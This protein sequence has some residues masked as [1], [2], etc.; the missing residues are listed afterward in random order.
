MIINN[1]FIVFDIYPNALF[2]IE[3][4]IPFPCV[5]NEFIIYCTPITFIY[6]ESFVI[7][8]NI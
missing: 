4:I 2:I 1:P 6:D 3:L 5:Y 7:S 8:I